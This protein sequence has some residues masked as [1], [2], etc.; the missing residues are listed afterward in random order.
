MTMIGLLSSFIL[1]RQIPYYIDSILLPLSNTFSAIAL[2]YLGFTMFGKIRNLSFS[3]IVV[4]MV[5][6]FAKSVLYPLI[7]RE[8]VLHLSSGGNMTVED[9]E[10]LSTFGF[11][12]GTFPTAP[13]LFFYNTRYK[14]IGDELVS[15]ALVFGTLASAP[16]MMISGD[17][18]NIQIFKV[19]KH[20]NY[21][22]ISLSEKRRFKK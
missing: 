2:F 18:K 14:A 19:P 12:Y 22:F 16:L 4:I 8:L 10:S 1:H 9:T 21:T 17:L 5:L 20:L 11:L 15:S 3:T 7:T 6:I 13:S